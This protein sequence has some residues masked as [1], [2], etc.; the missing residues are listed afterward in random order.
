VLLSRK[1]EAGKF[2]PT[3]T[4]NMK[5]SPSALLRGILLPA[6]MLTIFSLSACKKGDSA[7]RGAEGNG[8]AGGGTAFVTS[9]AWSYPGGWSEK[10]EGEQPTYYSTKY[11][12]IPAPQIT[13]EIVKHGMVLVYF[14]PS[15]DGSFMPLPYR[16]ESI[17][18]DYNFSFEYSRGNIRV[19][20]YYSPKRS[21][22]P[23]PS[24]ASA[25]VKDYTFKYVIVPGA[26][27]VKKQKDG[28][29]LT[30]YANTNQYASVNH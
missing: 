18:H 3:T 11:T 12:D 29:R 17:T 7:P 5:Q 22:G 28:I 1:N 2:A 24:L 15:D 13:D 14:N 4:P 21:S 26:S 25:T 8:N 16:L 9:A 27:S 19:H 10:Q 6:M 30:E 23:M 20:F